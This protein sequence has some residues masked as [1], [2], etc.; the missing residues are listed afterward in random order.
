MVVVEMPVQAACPSVE[1]HFHFDGNSHKT[2]VVQS[3]VGNA[4]ILV[5]PKMTHGEAYECETAQHAG[6]DDEDGASGGAGSGAEEEEEKPG[7]EEKPGEEE[8]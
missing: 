3:D 5:G 4:A 1:P 8:E 7:D 2:R 6:D